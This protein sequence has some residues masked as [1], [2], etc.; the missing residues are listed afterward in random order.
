MNEPDDPTRLESARRPLA[1]SYPTPAYGAITFH[2]LWINS[3]VLCLECRQCAKRTALTKVDLPQ[4]RLGNVRYG[5]HAA[6]KCSACGA[7]KPRL[8]EV[9][10]D[11]AKMFLAG[12]PLRRQIGRWMSF[13]AFAT[14]MCSHFAAAAPKSDCTSIPARCAVEIGGRCDPATG[15]WRFGGYEAG[16]TEQAHNACITRELAKQKKRVLPPCDRASGVCYP[17]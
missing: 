15:Q 17:K 4:S 3:G 13:V 2:Q 5:L 11:E 16:R 6:F 8:Y 9:T 10:Q 7:D 1:P 14:I 12:D